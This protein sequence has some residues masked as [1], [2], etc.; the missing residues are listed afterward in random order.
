MQCHHGQK[1]LNHVALL[2]ASPPRELIGSI[3]VWTGHRSSRF[4]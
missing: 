4:A 1:L 2:F 3:D